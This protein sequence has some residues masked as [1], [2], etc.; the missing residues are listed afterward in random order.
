MATEAVPASDAPPTYLVGSIIATCLCF[1]PLGLVAV[2][3]AWR[4]SA[5]NAAG[6]PDRASRASRSARRWLIATVAVGVVVDLIL[7]SALALLGAF[8]T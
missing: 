4:T 7:A 6:D 5:L 3:F 8:G 1:L 2:V